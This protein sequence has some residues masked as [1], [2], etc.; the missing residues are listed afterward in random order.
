MREDRLYT[1]ADF[2]DSPPGATEQLYTDADFADPVEMMSAHQPALMAAHAPVTLQDLSGVKVTSMRPK[3]EGDTNPPDP[4]ST[5]SGALAVPGLAML[6]GVV[7]SVGGLLQT[8]GRVAHGI[9]RLGDVPVNVMGPG[10]PAPTGP[11]AA[12]IGDLLDAS[13]GQLGRD[14]EAVSTPEGSSGDAGALIENPA[15]AV[16]HPVQALKMGAVASA[17]LAREVGGLPVGIGEI[18]ALGPTFPPVA[19]LERY[20]EGASL[21]ESA[22]E[23][24]MQALLLKFLHATGGVNLLARVAAQ[25]SAGGLS[26]L[27]A[28]AT[29][30]EAG[31]SALVWGGMAALGGGKKKKTAPEPA[32][33]T[34][35]PEHVEALFSAVK[36]MG[37][38]PARV[39][40][41][42]EAQSGESIEK[43]SDQQAADI[44]QVVQDH[45]AIFAERPKAPADLTLEPGAEEFDAA[46]REPLPAPGEGFVPPENYGTVKAEDVLR[47]PQAAADAVKAMGADELQKTLVYT[48]ENPSDPAIAEAVKAEMRRRRIPVDSP[49]FASELDAILRHYEPVQQEIRAGLDIPQAEETPK[50]SEAFDAGRTAARGRVRNGAAFAWVYGPEVG[51]KKTTAGAMV[52]F[53]GQTHYI[54]TTGGALEYLRTGSTYDDGGARITQ[55]AGLAGEGVHPALAPF[56]DAG[57]AG[58]GVDVRAGAG[59]PPQE[60]GR[61]P[62]V[63]APP[64]GQP[65]FAP[66]APGERTAPEGIEGAQGKGI[67]PADRH[68]PESGR[69]VPTSGYRGK[70]APKEVP[71]ETRSDFEEVRDP[72]LADYIDTPYK[73][74][75]FPSWANEPRPPKQLGEDL[76]SDMASAVYEKPSDTLA[77]QTGLDPSDLQY[78]REELPHRQGVDATEKQ[79]LEEIFNRGIAGNMKRMVEGPEWLPPFLKAGGDSATLKAAARNLVKGKEPT[80]RQKES[81]NL[82]HE[83]SAGVDAEEM[84]PYLSGTPEATKLSRQIEHGRAQ[85]HDIGALLKRAAEYLRA[86]Q[87][88]DWTPFRKVPGPTLPQEGEGIR[89]TAATDPME[90]KPFGSTPGVFGEVP[91]KPFIRPQEKSPASKVKQEGLFDSEGRLPFRRGDWKLIPGTAETVDTGKLSPRD[92]QS[93]VSGFNRQ[94]GGAQVEVVKRADLPER[95]RN[96]PEMDDRVKG[97]MDPRTGRVLILGE[98]VA[99]PKDLVSTVYHEKVGHEGISRAFRGRLD[100]L[101]QS[102]FDARSEDIA[103]FLKEQGYREPF[104]KRGSISNPK[105]QRYSAAEYLAHASENPSM[106]GQP[107]YRRAVAKVRLALRQYGPSSLARKLKWTDGEIREMLSRG[108]GWLEKN[109]Q[110]ASAQGGPMP[111]KVDAFHGTGADF[112]R[113]DSSYMGTGE[114]A[115]AYGWGHYFTSKKDIAE[116]Y[117]DAISKKQW[118]IERRW[119]LDGKRLVR[120]EVPIRLIHALEFVNPYNPNLDDKIAL[121][122]AMKSLD[123]EVVWRERDN[124]PGA[125]LY[126]NAAQT[127]R[128]FAPRLTPKKGAGGFLYRT[129]LLPDKAAGEEVWLDWRHRASPEILKKISRALETQGKPSLG[130]N[131]IVSGLDKAPGSVTGEHLYDLLSSHL[132]TPKAASLFLKSLGIDGVRYEADQGKRDGE[133]NYVVFDDNDIAIDEKVAFRKKKEEPSLDFSPPGTD[134]ET[135]G[136]NEREQR[137]LPLRAEGRDEGGGRDQAGAPR[138]DRDAYYHRAAGS[139]GRLSPAQSKVARATQ[140]SLP[141]GSQPTLRNLAAEAVSDLYAEETLAAKNPDAILQ[142]QNSVADK[143]ARRGALAL[144]GH[145]VG[146]HSDLAALAQVLRDPRIETMRAIF[147]NGDGVVVGHASVTSRHPAETGWNDLRQVHKTVADR[148]RRLKASSY[149]MLHNHPSEVLDPS[150]QDFGST[151]TIGKRIPGLQGHIITDYD[152]YG[153][154]DPQGHFEQYPLSPKLRRAHQAPLPENPVLKA[155]GTGAIWNSR[156]AQ[157]EAEGILEECARLGITA[158]EGK[159]LAIFCDVKNK[160]RHFEFFDPG[161]L[162]DMGM[163]A[164]TTEEVEK[165]AG[166]RGTLRGISRKYGAPSIFWYVPKDVPVYQVEG[167]FEVLATLGQAQDILYHETARGKEKVESA[168]T[169]VPRKGS[170]GRTSPPPSIEVQEDTP[171]D[172]RRAE[173]SRTVA[174]PGV[175]LGAP[176]PEAAQLK[177]LWD[178]TL[179]RRAVSAPRLDVG[180][181]LPE[182]IPREARGRSADYLAEEAGKPGKVTGN[183]LYRLLYRGARAGRGAWDTLGKTEAGAKYL[184]KGEQAWWDYHIVATDRKFPV[185]DAL[186]TLTRDEMKWARE[187]FLETYEKRQADPSDP[188][189]NRAEAEASRAR[190]LLAKTP[191]IEK[192]TLAWQHANEKVGEDAKTHKIQVRQSDGDTR[193]FIPRDS[194]TYVPHKLTPEAREQLNNGRGPIFEALWGPRRA[195]MEVAYTKAL[196]EQIPEGAQGEQLKKVLEGFAKEE[197]GAI[198]KNSGVLKWL[199]KGG[200]KATPEE[201]QNHLLDS[202]GKITDFKKH[203][204]WEL[205]QR[206][207]TTKRHGSL[208]NHREMRLPFSVRTKDGKVL[209]VLQT[210]PTL[211]LRHIDSAVRRIAIAKHFGPKTATR[212]VEEMTDA[213]VAQGVDRQ[214]AQQ[215]VV[216]IWNRLQG[217]DQG[218]DLLFS[219]PKVKTAYGVLDATT[220][221]SNL[222][223]ASVQNLLGGHMPLTV[224]SGLIPAAKAFYW[225][226][227]HRL[228]SPEAK[229]LERRGAILDNVEAAYAATESLEGTFRKIASTVLKGTGFTWANEHINLAVAYHWASSLEGMVNGIRQNKP[230]AWWREAFASGWSAPRARRYLA[231]QLKFSPEDIDRMVKEGAGEKD[232]R[233]AIFKEQELVNAMNE[234]PVERPALINRPLFNIIFRYSSYVRKFADTV[235]YG[236]REAEKGNVMPLTRLLVAGAVTGEA[237]AAVRNLIQ[238]RKREDKGFLQRLYQDMLEVGSFG[239]LGQ[240]SYW[241]EHRNQ[242]GSSFMQTVLEPPI[243]GTLTG[244]LNGVSESI[245]EKSLRPLWEAQ[246]RNASLLRAVERQTSHAAE[247]LPAP[248]PIKDWGRRQLVRRLYRMVYQTDGTNSKGAYHNA[249]EPRPDNTATARMLLKRYRDMGLTQEDLVDDMRSYRAER[250]A[251]RNPVQ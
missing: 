31:R 3:G 68:P 226:F 183:I 49:E 243:V 7:G 177:D 187:H 61:V 70:P 222:S 141:L 105:W 77:S 213:M 75:G 46:P 190:V 20:G 1:D 215:S 157:A 64:P 82:W 219:S 86:H 102:L 136:R 92:I 41:W 152:S 17:P 223:T 168:F 198:L 15:S 154:I 250:E 48:L 122:A 227:T 130:L 212:T 26:T 63:V 87:D 79:R 156:K 143:L 73:T 36:G 67:P 169:V 133:Y 91:N 58:Q 137:P 164:S 107:W 106:Y 117:R 144:I 18:T 210:D 202:L 43:V 175:P 224:R 115:Q 232:I 129:V 81:L 113:F 14:M 201:I 239:F 40:A 251:G 16:I 179:G 110:G 52:A 118:P 236:I 53:N 249:L 120:D 238:D 8:P 47:A 211:L 38:D 132:K 42:V 200:W 80:A 11:V 114:G 12:K 218:Y 28:G 171:D 207:L 158:P 100:P 178:K 192:L 34:R 30:E 189:V 45:R 180:T 13:L 209:N 65:P 240:F 203:P 6:Q 160:A 121:D 247:T 231:E 172:W 197:N 174:R 99:G 176:G 85:G 173:D 62:E 25:A 220:A 88:D 97:F 126:R 225:S 71:S 83:A 162:G 54:P 246:A 66:D 184:R 145:E 37:V 127:L 138:S 185:A 242:Y 21:G 50:N 56:R 217:S 112:D 230:T 135:G 229:S 193:P 151:R 59:P 244:L 19:G 5:L 245:G 205:S 90:E 208:E 123:A 84:L 148:M 98:R 23:A 163:L 104:D 161:L 55:P 186:R 108:R 196:L 233:R 149:Y 111:L 74:E 89:P 155:V 204:I 199:A 167:A 33:E 237:V 10:G 93:L 182:I 57:A 214:T 96:H 134:I 146:S 101:L 69:V 195:R 228:D 72:D 76:L 140:G 103:G 2:E 147:L 44:L 22:T 109:A 24:A 27:A 131:L 153:F 165:R 95:L 191:G 194:I 234:S 181:P 39:R 51:G 116:Y 125:D 221:A 139:T 128:E 166:I 206:D 119:M 60:P 150:P 78:M 142:R 29:P 241:W 216:P 188:D 32:P 94:W 170:L 124:Y 4:E 35:A 235:D 248:K 159:V 9:A